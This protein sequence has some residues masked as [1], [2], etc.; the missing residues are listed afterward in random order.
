LAHGLSQYWIK[1]TGYEKSDYT[2][3][4]RYH[5]LC[6]IGMYLLIGFIDGT[7]LLLTQIKGENLYSAK[8]W[9][10]LILRI[11]MFNGFPF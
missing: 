8:A 9:F 11:S 10:F 2:K 7:G 1:K 6:V 3:E 5:F 4:L